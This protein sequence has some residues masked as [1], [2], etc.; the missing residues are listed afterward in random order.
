[1]PLGNF[2]DFVNAVSKEAA[3]TKYLNT[4]Q[5]KKKKPNENFA[6]ELMELFTL[7]V[8]HYTESDIKESA[9]AFTGYSHNVNGDFLLKKQQHDTGLKTF[10]GETGSFTGED[11]IDLILKKKQCAKYVCG[12][13]YAYF[14]NTKI[15]DAHVEQ[16]AEVFY[17]DYNIANLMRFVLMSNWFYEDKN[18]G[19]KI[20]SPIEFLV[21]M[22]TTVPF[23]FKNKKRLLHIENVLGQVLFNP[24]NVAGWKGGKSWIDS[25]TIILRLKLPSLLL[26]DAYISKI[27][28]NSNTTNAERKAMLKKRNSKQYQTNTNWQVFQSNFKNVETQDLENYLLTCKINPEA[29]QYLS[30]LKKES[31]REYCIQIMSLPEYQMC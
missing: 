6:R 13:I 8:G 20:K 31:K 27:E 28:I 9:R 29:A 7:G 14:V 21:G 24:P 5:N 2:K 26:N 15:N 17:K 10:F 23:Q 30:A 18:I 16:M 3:M 4:K 19:N 25:N 11:I 1:L 22:K 12:K